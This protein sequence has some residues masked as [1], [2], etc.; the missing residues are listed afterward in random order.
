MVKTNFPFWYEFF[1]EFLLQGSELTDNYYNTKTKLYQWLTI[2]DKGIKMESV[3]DLVIRPEFD[4]VVKTLNGKIIPI[5][6][7]KLR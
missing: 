2:A 1:V 6:G 7:Q 3:I 5:T 4:F